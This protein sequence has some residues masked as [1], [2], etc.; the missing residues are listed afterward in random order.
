MIILDSYQAARE[1]LEERSKNY[2]S[3]LPHLHAFIREVYRILPDVAGVRRVPHGSGGGRIRTWATRSPGAVV[4]T[5]NHSLG[6]DAATFADPWTFR[7]KRWIENPQLPSANVGYGRRI[8]P[9]HHLAHNSIHVVTARLLWG[10]DMAP[11]VAD[12]QTLDPFD[13]NDGLLFRP[14]PFKA[15]FFARSARHRAVIEQEW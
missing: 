8:C 2:S 1:L 11:V 12:G 4:V 7:P 13:V 9:G 5:N 15:C 14:S 10:Y 3:R 6:F